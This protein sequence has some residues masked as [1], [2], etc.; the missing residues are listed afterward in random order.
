[1]IFF[2]LKNCMSYDT[3]QTDTDLFGSEGTD[4]GEDAG[5]TQQ[6]GDLLEESNQTEVADNSAKV[7]RQKQI[8]A[9][10]AKGPDGLEKL[11][12]DKEWLR[13]HV[14]ARFKLMDKE[15][16][17]EKIIE[18]KMAAKEADKRYNDHKALLK[19]MKLKGDQQAKI[20]TRQDQLLARGVP[21]DE[22]LEIAME[23]AG[24]SL[25]PEDQDRM[26]LR[27]R[28][29]V[30]VQ[31]NNRVVDSDAKVHDNDFH[32]KVTDPKEKMRLLMANLRQPN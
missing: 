3:T 12:P 22:A 14:E 5:T 16:E 24:I 2:N 4:A 6:E 7:Q 19:S 28:M 26:I 11:P 25:D 23:A 10:V 1:M 20:Q 15:P 18:Q 30:P 27:Q 21:K 8:D 31:G 13:S 29:A 9:W 17:I 32:S